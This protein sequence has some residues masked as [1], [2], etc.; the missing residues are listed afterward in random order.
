MLLELSTRDGG[1]VKGGLGGGGGD[2]DS[3]V[4]FVAVAACFFVTLIR[5]HLVSFPLAQGTIG[6]YYC[7]QP[8]STIVLSK[9]SSS[10]VMRLRMRWYCPHVLFLL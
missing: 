7:T 10:R 9:Y 4:A 1:N 3:I 2:E 5:E 6:V 8:A